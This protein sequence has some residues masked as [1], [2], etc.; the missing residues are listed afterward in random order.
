MRRFVWLLPVLALTIGAWSPVAAPAGEWKKDAQA[1]TGQVITMGEQTAAESQTEGD[2]NMVPMTILI[3]DRQFDASLFDNA[4][5][6][7]LIEQMPLTVNMSELHGNE[8]YY[9]LPSSLPTQAQDVGAIR[10]GDLMLF[11][12]DCLV[13]F[14]EDFSTSYRY[15][16]LGAISNPEGLQEALGG[17]SVPVTF[18]LKP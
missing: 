9:Y 1:G 13:L 5:T 8:K 2:E 10:T 7:A 12:S 15:T 16:R 4:S 17:G 11:G 14:Y 3:G 18:Q 6:Q